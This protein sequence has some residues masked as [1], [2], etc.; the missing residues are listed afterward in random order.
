MKKIIGYA[1]CVAV[2]CFAIVASAE[3]DDRDFDFDVA[4][5][6]T[7]SA[8]YAIHGELYGIYVD[9]AAG[10]TSGTITVSSQQDTFLTVTGITADTM[11]YPRID[12]M[13]LT[14]VTN[15]TYGIA[16]MSGPVTVTVIGANDATRINEYKTKIL[17]NK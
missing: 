5:K 4:Y 13:N 11:Y 8:T 1:L 6:L 10:A 9:V 7:N 17:F 12:T 14:G 16:P 3:M 2:A 15:K